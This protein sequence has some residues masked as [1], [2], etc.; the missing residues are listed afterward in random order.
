MNK[1]NVIEIWFRD[2]SLGTHSEQTV[3][4]PTNVDSFGV[5]VN[6]NDKG[7]SAAT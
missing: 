3:A 5:I 4:N 2:I 1:I 7:G 6:V